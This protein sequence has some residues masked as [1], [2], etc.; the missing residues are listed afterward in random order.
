MLNNTLRELVTVVRQ[1]ADSTARLLGS[2]G[3]DVEDMTESMLEEE[4]AG[5]RRSVSPSRGSRLRS[6]SPT[7]ARSPAMSDNV[8]A[9]VQSCIHKRNLQVQELKSRAEAA[10]EAATSSKKQLDDSENER[11]RLEKALTSARDEV[12]AV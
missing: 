8:L 11:K 6:V 5:V 2:P 1:D 12:D 3:P 10:R 4:D 7:R 9:T